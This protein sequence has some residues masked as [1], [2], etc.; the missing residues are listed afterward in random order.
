M[1]EITPLAMGLNQLN[2]G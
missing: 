2:G 1:D